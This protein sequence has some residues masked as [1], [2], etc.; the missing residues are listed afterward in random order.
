[1]SAPDR[2][3]YTTESGL[4]VSPLL[5]RPLCPNEQS[6]IDQVNDREWKKHRGDL[7]EEKMPK[8]DQT[9]SD[10]DHNAVPDQVLVPLWVA[11]DIDKRD[12]EDDHQQGRQ[13]D[14]AKMFRKGHSKSR[15]DLRRRQNAKQTQNAVIKSGGD[16]ERSDPRFHCFGF[17]H[18][19]PPQSNLFCCGIIPSCRSSLEMIRSTA[20]GP[21]I[22]P[23]RFFF[24]SMGW[25]PTPPAGI[26]SVNISP[27]K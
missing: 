17:S 16:K 12:R 25:G 11:G 26:F 6:N 27:E 13:M 10:L 4:Q 1:M 8:S 24:S 2:L 18:A 23:G 5:S 14:V 19:R 3:P 9:K 7:A 21:P 22:T 20:N 15:V